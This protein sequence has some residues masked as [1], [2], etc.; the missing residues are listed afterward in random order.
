MPEL[1]EVETIRRML[2]PRLT[3]Q[4]I[5]QA[6]FYEPRVLRGDPSQTAARL[7]GQT[8]R[9]VRRRGKHLLVEFDSGLLLAVHL[10][11][12][13]SLEWGGRRGP[14]ARALFLLDEG[15]V[16][17]D[18][19][20][21]FGCIELCE[22]VPERIARLGPE[23]L[24]IKPAEFIARLH[25]R[26]AMVKPLLLNQAFLGGLGNIYTDEALFRAGIHPRANAAR[27]S[28]E[29]AR[30]LYQAI[31]AVLKAAIASGGT[32]ISD[33]V[34]PEGRRGGFQ[35]RLRV[36]GRAGEPC[37]RC[38]A[39]IQRTVIGQRGTYFCARCQRR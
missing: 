29:R 11:M 22:G 20:R 8:I 7:R 27:L 19:P 18:D 10:G 1:P 39:P 14:H 36:Y 15:R 17:Y 32:S 38:Q 23:P 25:A 16:L 13:G 33:Y 3:G 2:E 34:D 31:R 28:R 5:T 30:K 21:M 26:R 6:E 9:A 35:V 12:T 37:P 4:R 24:E